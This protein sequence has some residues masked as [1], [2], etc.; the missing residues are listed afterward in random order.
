[1]YQLSG[2]ISKLLDS[3]ELETLQNAHKGSIEGIYINQ[4]INILREYENAP[5]SAEMLSLLK[6]H[7][8]TLLL[9]ENVLK[10]CVWDF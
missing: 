9:L 3:K 6:S 1:M 4:D 10:Y 8:I 7:E 2:I 5:D